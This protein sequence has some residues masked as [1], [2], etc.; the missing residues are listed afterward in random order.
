MSPFANP[1]EAT[2]YVYPEFPQ[3]LVEVYEY[4]NLEGVQEY[5]F[6]GFNAGDS[7]YTISDDS[8]PVVQPALLQDFKEVLPA[9]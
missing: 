4:S 9:S 6:K 8:M 3:P 1:E 2:P 7:S 5:H